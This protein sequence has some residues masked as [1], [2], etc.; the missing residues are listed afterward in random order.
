MSASKKSAQPNEIDLDRLT[1]QAVNLRAVAGD[2]VMTQAIELLRK[3]LK[4][5]PEKV[6]L[7]LLREIA[8]DWVLLAYEEEEVRDVSK[9]CLAGMKQRG[10]IPQICGGVK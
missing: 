2:E 1:G 4:L 6:M 8:P 9:N 10:E 7:L 3:R 5:T